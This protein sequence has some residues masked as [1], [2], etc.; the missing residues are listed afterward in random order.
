MTIEFPD[1]RELVARAN[2]GDSDALE[3]LYRRHRDWVVSVAWR[4]TGDR[5]DALD[6]LQDT[7]AHL[8]GRFPGF[9][10]RSS[11]RAYLY[12]VVKHTCISIARKRR[13]VVPFE[14]AD[15][16]A[17]APLA[18]TAAP[19][20]WS[21]EFERTIAGLPETHR[22]VLRLRMALGMQI[23][24]IA[25]ALDIPVGTVK[26]RLHNALQ[27]LAIHENDDKRTPE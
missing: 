24:E 25:H 1:D 12:P 23:A 20:E 27:T 7:F 11:M 5:D 22:E 26:S 2:R 18:E 4:L 6:A 13:R 14:A 3:A 17:A 10:L 15:R 21:A 19:P 9:E 16:G 8:L